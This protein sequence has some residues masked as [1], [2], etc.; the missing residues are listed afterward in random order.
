MKTYPSIKEGDTKDIFERLEG[1]NLIEPLALEEAEFQIFMRDNRCAT[2][3]GH[4][5]GHHEPGR[6]YSAYC[7]EH[8]VIHSH[9]YIS[10]YKAEQVKQGVIDG[11][12]ELKDKPKVT[13]SAEE[14]IKELGF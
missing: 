10:A 13:R 6:L 14:I 7:P 9:N 1:E 3:A 2:C 8:G 11:T 5:I 4:L 12:H